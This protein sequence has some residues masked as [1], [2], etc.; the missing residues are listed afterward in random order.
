M[1]ETPPRAGTPDVNRAYGVL[2][3]SFTESLQ[4]SREALADHQSLLP[5]GRLADIDALLAE[6]NQRRV[7]IAVYGEVKAG[8]STLVNALAGAALSPTAFDPLTSLPLRV[9]YG[10]QTAWR[11]DGH[12]F[13]SVEEL[14]EAMRSGTA[15]GDEVEVTT[16]LDLLRLGGQVDVVDTPGVGSEDRFDVISAQV[17]RTLDAVVLVVRYPAL[18]TQF[19]RRLVDQL[20]SDISKLFVVWNLDAACAEL[21]ADERER[22]GQTLR[23]NVAGAHQLY[24]VDAKRGFDAARNKAESELVASGLHSL[25]AGLAEFAG[26]EKREISALREASKRAQL[27]LEETVARLQ[28]RQKILEASTSAARIQLRTAERRADE[29]A[30][31]MRS[32][33]TTLQSALA[34]IARKQHD[35]AAEAASTLRKQLRSA[36]RGWVRRADKPSLTTAI[37]TATTDYADAIDRSTFTATDA[38]HQSARNFDTAIAVA[39]RLRSIPTIDEIAPAEREERARSGSLPLLRRALWRNWYLPGLSTLEGATIEEDLAAQR[40][41][42]DDAITAATNAA[43]TTLDERLAQIRR[44]GESEIAEIKS[45]TNYDAEST[46]L[47]NLNRHV[48]VLEGARTQINDVAAEAWYLA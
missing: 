44:E 7:R 6:F 2:A 33:F 26:S 13:A 36:A 31:D 45:A 22:Q 4:D 42:L 18:F 12:T 43:R 30:D 27:W 48:P 46:E 21:S 39:P 10:P 16:A 19:T 15:Q 8:K 37:E 41:W 35:A 40:R 23:Q 25:I 5:E 29:R 34:D 32:R 24:L 9:T 38:L 28:D 17:L 20:Q 1:T 11:V 3:T 14:A 47:D